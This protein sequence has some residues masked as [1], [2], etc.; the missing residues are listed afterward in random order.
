MLQSSL[1]ADDL[2]TLCNLIDQN[3]NQGAA[4]G[5]EYVNFTINESMQYIHQSLMPALKKA[6]KKQLLSEPEMIE[7][8]I[9]FVDVIVVKWRTDGL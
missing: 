8:L 4:I 3:S 5:E 9:S 7:A 6:S 1:L 2:L